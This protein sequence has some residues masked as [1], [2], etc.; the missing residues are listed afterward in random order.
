MVSR[1]LSADSCLKII[2]IKLCTTTSVVVHSLFTTE[3]GN[4]RGLVVALRLH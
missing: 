1:I 3:D 4:L 2:D